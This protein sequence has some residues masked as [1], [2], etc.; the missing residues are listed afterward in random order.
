M[1]ATI[2]IEGKEFTIDELKDLINNQQSPMNKVY[3]FHRTTKEEFDKSYEKLPLRSKY[4]EIEAMVVAY[5]NDGWIYKP[6]DKIYYPYFQLA[7]FG[8]HYVDNILSFTH[9]PLAL[10]FKNKKLLEEAVEEFKEEY[11]LSRLTL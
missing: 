2:N 6:G 7:P 1:K 4:L 5:K 10:C 11:N 9:V 3:A 8:F